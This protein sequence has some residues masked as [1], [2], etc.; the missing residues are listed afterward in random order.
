MKNFQPGQGSVG[1]ANNLCSMWHELNWTSDES[2]PDWLTYMA[3]NLVSAASW[4]SVRAEGLD[5]QFLSAR[6][7]SCGPLQRLLVGLLIS[8]GL[9]SQNKCPKRIR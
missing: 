5:L 7:S 4:S 9:G 8:R 3:G 2:L 6:V 1:K